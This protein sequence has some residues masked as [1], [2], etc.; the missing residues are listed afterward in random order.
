MSG[1]IGQVVSA[2]AKR[3]K[4]TQ[5]RTE[6]DFELRCELYRFADLHYATCSRIVQETLEMEDK[7]GWKRLD[8]HLLA[9]LT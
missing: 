7:Y 3:A 9:C 6:W 2:P 1:P 4:K 5:L 8:E